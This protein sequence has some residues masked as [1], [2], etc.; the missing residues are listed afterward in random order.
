MRNADPNLTQR[1]MRCRGIANDTK[2]A[3]VNGLNQVDVPSQHRASKGWGFAVLCSITETDA[4]LS[5]LPCC[6]LCFGTGVFVLRP[7]WGFVARLV[8]TVRVAR[9]ADWAELREI[10]LI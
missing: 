6:Q 1:T 8:R 4:V 10:G 5:I 3:C 2:A 7:I 9:R